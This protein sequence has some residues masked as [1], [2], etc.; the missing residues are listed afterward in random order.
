LESLFLILSQ[1]IKGDYSNLLDADNCLAQIGIKRILD[2]IQASP[3]LYQALGSNDLD[4]S[5]RKV[6]FYQ[7]LNLLLIEVK[8][9]ESVKVTLTVFSPK[10]FTIDLFAD[11]N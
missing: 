6:S 4:E 1:V 7:K 2:L 3:C 8:P 11:Q 10:V 9:F 5:W